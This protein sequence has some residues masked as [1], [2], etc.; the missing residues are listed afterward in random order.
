MRSSSSGSALR[1]EQV[2]REEH[3]ALLVD[4]PGRGVE[5]DEVPPGARALADLLGEL[6]LGGL[7]RALA[8]LVEL[9]GR[10]L[11]QGRLVDGLA[12]LADQQQ[13]LAVVGHDR[14]GA[15]VRDH[16][17]LGLLPVLVAEPVHPHR[18][19]PPLPDGLAADPLEA[20][21][22]PAATIASVRSSIFSSASTVTDSSGWWLRWVPLARL[23]MGSP[24]AIRAFASLPPPVLM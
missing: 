13:A 23:T 18:C 5:G 3:V 1:V 17:A 14:D 6:A 22:A 8:L 24:A 12:R 19:D 16:L 10:Q 7:E 21:L 4:E 15:R 9:A 20:H 11:Q 2:G